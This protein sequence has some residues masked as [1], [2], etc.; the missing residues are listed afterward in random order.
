[1]NG[2][3]AMD[4]DPFIGRRPL[5]SDGRVEKRHRANV[6]VHLARTKEPRGAERTFTRDVSPHGARVVTMQPWHS[7]DEQLLTP[8][9]GEFPQLA[10]V[11]YCQPSPAGGYYVGLHFPVRS[12]RWGEAP[13]K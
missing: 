6:P 10:R 9:T 5:L 3:L 12:V 1:L 8:L 13:S 4:S 2:L 11:V 7:G